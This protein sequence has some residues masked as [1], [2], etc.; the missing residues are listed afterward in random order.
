[1][2]KAVKTFQTLMRGRPD[3]GK[4]SPDYA[5]GF[6]ETLSYLTDEELGWLTDPREGLATRCKFL[7]TPA[8]VFELIRERK[9]ARDAVRPAPTTYRRLADEKGPWDEE[10]DYERKKRVVKELLGYSPGEQMQA[11]PKVLE[12]PPE[13]FTVQLKTP[14]APVSD[15]LKDLLREQGWPVVEN[16]NGDAA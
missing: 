2:A 3:Y 11:R 15:A 16:K 13:G 10:T 6:T 5:V 14:A 8:D 12:T 9:A 1:M 4:E 7:P